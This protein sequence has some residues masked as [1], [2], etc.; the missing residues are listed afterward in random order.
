M[1]LIHSGELVDIIFHNKVDSIMLTK[2]SCASYGIMHYS[3][4]RDDIL[5]VGND[6]MASA[7]FYFAMERHGEYFK[8]SQESIST[9]KGIFLDTEIEWQGSRFLVR[10]YTKPSHLGIPLSA[11]RPQ[12]LAGGNDKQIE[13]QIQH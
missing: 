4:F 6:A 8:I 7:R 5:F 11:T 9:K 2:E 13:V 12:E 3:R 10:P 1:G